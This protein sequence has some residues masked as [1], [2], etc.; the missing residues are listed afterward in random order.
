[1]RALGPWGSLRGMEQDTTPEGRRRYIAL[2]RSKTPV[3]RLEIAASLT[4]AAREMTM[5]GIRQRHPEASE[6]EV[7]AR[8][9]EIVYGPE[10][11]RRLSRSD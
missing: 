2:L 6:E 1:M 9:T 10:A 4:A 3:E 8:F 7:R 5:A 11:A